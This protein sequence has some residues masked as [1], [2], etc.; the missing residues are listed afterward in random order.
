MADQEALNQLMQ[1][2]AVEDL[3]AATLA[4]RQSVRRHF[5]DST[6]DC[7]TMEALAVL[8]EHGYRLVRQTD[9]P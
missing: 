1:D 6:C 5:L 4:L 7:P 8:Y 9:G 3:Q 2:L